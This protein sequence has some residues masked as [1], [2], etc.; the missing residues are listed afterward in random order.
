MQRPIFS[1]L[2]FACV[3]VI[4][5]VNSV[6]VLHAQD[7][8]GNWVRLFRNDTFV[9][10]N[11][12]C[13]FELRPLSV[14]GQAQLSRLS[15]LDVLK[16]DGIEAELALSKR[17]LDKLDTLQKESQAELRRILSE[18]ERRFVSSRATVS[19]D[20][21]DAVAAWFADVESDMQ[22]I[23]LKDQFER[24][25]EV[26]R[27]FERR[28]QGWM[29]VLRRM[30]QDRRLGLTSINN[31]GVATKLAAIAD[32]VEEKARELSE[33]IVE[34][35]V[36]VLSDKQ[37]EKLSMYTELFGDD[38]PAIPLSLLVWQLRYFDNFSAGD[39]SVAPQQGKVLLETYRCVPIFVVNKFGQLEKHTTGQSEMPM[40]DAYVS[41]QSMLSNEKVSQILAL[42]PEQLE[43][44]AE[45]VDDCRLESNAVSDRHKV[46]G[47]LSPRDVNQMYEDVASSGVEKFLAV[48]LP[49]QRAS[50]DYIATALDYYRRGAV[51]A[52]CDGPLQKELEI[53][54]QQVKQITNA[55]KRG[56]RT[57]EVRSIEIEAEVTDAVL[58]IV[59][60][61]ASQERIRE[62]FG[63]PLAHVPV[64]LELFANSLRMKR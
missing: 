6:R 27:T 21:H 5:V 50:L 1:R 13:E 44:V 39:V 32:E 8:T 63:T 15:P 3:A 24:F 30:S 47:N 43:Q 42:S 10:V 34:D 31:Q 59:G 56:L 26:L 16:H 37:R 9:I 22:Q 18:I 2:V 41:Y 36:E 45:I 61:E 28:N 55:A 49:H 60:E 64:N 58:A 54:K 29:T 48:L 46:N 33:S 52:I 19:R 53:T 7:S 17:Q 62:Y 38:Q 12:K 4:A 20:D 25:Q 40:Y 35:I 11:A 51:G 14:G 57:I 23:L